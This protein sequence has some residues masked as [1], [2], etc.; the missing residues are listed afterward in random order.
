MRTGL[1]GETLGAALKGAASRAATQSAR[2]ALLTS[3]DG[4]TWAAEDVATLVPARQIVGFAGAVTTS[5]G[6]VFLA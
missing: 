5:D 6:V 3:P 2:R 1:A 4:I